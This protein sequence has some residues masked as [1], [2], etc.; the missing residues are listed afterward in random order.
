MSDHGSCCLVPRDLPLP[1]RVVDVS[2]D[3]RSPRLLVTHGLIGEWVTLSHCWGQ[4]TTFRMTSRNVEQLQQ[5][6][7]FQSLPATMQD[8]I[9]VVRH[10]G[11]RYLWIDSLCIIQDSE[12]DWASES[13]RMQHYFENS[14]LTVAAD[15]AT[16]DHEG[17]LVCPRIPDRVIAT[18]PFH[19]KRTKDTC[20]VSIR[21]NVEYIGQETRVT[22]LSQRAW[23]LQEDLLSPRTLHFQTEYLC[24]ECQSH[25]IIEADLT[26]RGADEGDLSGITKRYF[27]QPEASMS[28]ALVRSY[29]S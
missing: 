7:P 4:E 3:P 22:K 15:D 11:Y 6:V 14:I 27:L 2:G 1:T 8:A 28:C 9:T 19:T 21:G 13:L 5:G 20:N 10:L 23:V 18:I 26:P 24:W 16:G 12:D 17:F 29:P 25:R